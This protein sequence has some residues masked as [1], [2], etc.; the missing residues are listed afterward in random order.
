M[1]ESK[2]VDPASIDEAGPPVAATG[3]PWLT[4]DQQDVD[5]L[6]LTL[7]DHPEMERARA[8]GVARLRQS[9]QAGVLDAEATLDESVENLAFGALQAAV[10]NDPTRPRVVW[11]ERLPYRWSGQLYPGCRYG[12]ETSDR[13]YRGIGV[14]PAYRYEIRG[15]RHPSHPSPCDFSVEAV[16]EPA[17]W[18]SPIQAVQAPEGIDVDADGTW[19]VIADATP[20]DGRRNHLHLPPATATLLV[21]DTMHDWARQV[22]NQV[23]VRVLNAPAAPPRSRDEIAA[24]GARIFLRCI[25]ETLT[26]FDNLLRPQRINELTPFYRAVRWGVPGGVIALNRFELD[27]D[28]ALV[29]TLDPITAGYLGILMSN[30]WM[31]SVA[32]DSRTASL[33]DAQAQRDDE[34]TYT[35]VLSPRDPGVHNWLDTGG[36]R[37]GLFL[38]RWERFE[39]E[40]VPV[41]EPVEG[42]QAAAWQPD[43]RIERAVREIHRVPLADVAEVIPAGQELVDAPR[44]AELNA[45]RRLAYEVRVHGCPLS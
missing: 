37:T 31:C 10:N 8:T 11:S 6:A 25:E 35:F 40:P 45:Q 3:T 42:A 24:D 26:L 36:L 43:N 21:R 41:P 22:P 18:G 5:N 39:T 34:G 20:T 7:L 23:S 15:R 44:R 28:E 9:L 32:Y 19:T 30:P 27:L 33:N 12:G 4:E 2:T 14:S 38:A 17:M 13:V 16:P 1:N 29:I